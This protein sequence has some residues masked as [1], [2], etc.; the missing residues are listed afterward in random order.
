MSTKLMLEKTELLINSL[1]SAR[2]RAFDSGNEI[3]TRLLSCQLRE[4]LALREELERAL[5]LGF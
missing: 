5:R 3:E 1:Q 2:E 4:A